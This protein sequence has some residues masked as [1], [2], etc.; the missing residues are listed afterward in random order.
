MG[1]PKPGRWTIVNVY[2]G[3]SASYSS[4]SVG[5]LRAKEA[6]GLIFEPKVYLVM[7]CDQPTID[8]LESE[9]VRHCDGAVIVA[10]QPRAK[11]RAAEC[12][13]YG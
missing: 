5:R 13:R 11:T 6:L 1:L 2:R 10:Q 4:S 12:D 9:I 3:E 7:V 8:E